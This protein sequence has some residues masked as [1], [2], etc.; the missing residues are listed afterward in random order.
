MG[1]LA[2]T[3]PAYAGSTEK[4]PL[5]LAIVAYQP[6]SGR[7][8]ATQHRVA[9]HMPHVQRVVDADGV[10]RFL[11]SMAQRSAGQRRPDHLVIVGRS[12][13]GAADL[14]LGGGRVSADDLDLG[15]ATR[16][17]AG[18]K[19][20][21]AS[22]SRAADLAATRH[23]QLLRAAADSLASDA[24][25]VLLNGPAADK[26]GK[27][28]AEALAALLLNRRTDAA[29]SSLPAT[30]RSRS[31]STRTMSRAGSATATSCTMARPTGRRTVRV[32]RS[33]AKRASA[34]ASTAS[35]VAGTGRT[36]LVSASPAREPNARWV[37]A[38]L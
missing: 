7:I 32:S 16:R 8:D 6:G 21:A 5:G 25:V 33:P 36:V 10:E 1:M 11:T 35:T 27:P 15:A 9:A 18:L 31:R 19:K 3:V 2:G 24:V 17:L 38:A 20:T 12:G 13:A 29:A 34:A 23:V 22:P 28:F 26:A 30:T 37:S 14:D 4:P